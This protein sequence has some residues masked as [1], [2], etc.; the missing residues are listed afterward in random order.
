MK[1]PSAFTSPEYS[2]LRS[3]F[4]I[5]TFCGIWWPSSLKGTAKQLFKVLASYVFASCFLIFLQTAIRVALTIGTD[6]F[7]IYNTFIAMTAITGCL[8]QLLILGSREQ[9]LKLVEICSKDKWHDPK[10]EE[11][12][13]QWT[14]YRSMTK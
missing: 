9:V 14:W 1:P 11:E 6:D 8:K 12:L 4:T 3:S 7:D 13:R 10:N 5:L 2:L